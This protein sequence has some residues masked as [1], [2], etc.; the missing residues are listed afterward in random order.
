MTRIADLRARLVA[1]ELRAAQ[2]LDDR[3]A[4]RVRPPVERDGRRY[5]PRDRRAR[6]SRQ[7]YLDGF[8]VLHQLLREP[9]TLGGPARTGSSG[10]GRGGGGMSTAPSRTDPVSRV[11]QA[12]LA[13]VEEVAG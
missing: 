6:L 4:A 2:R 9:G 11:A 5:C 10:R 13:V 12:A 3:Q 7:P 8:A 1:L